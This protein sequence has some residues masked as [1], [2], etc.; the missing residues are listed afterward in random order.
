LG[1][2]KETIV[3]KI[4]ETDQFAELMSAVAR[5]LPRDMYPTT[6]QGWIRN[7]G[8]LEKV[9]RAALMSTDPT[10]QFLSEVIASGLVQGHADS[11]GTK[12]WEV[13]QN[14]YPSKF[15][16]SDLELVSFLEEDEEVID[17]KE[18]CQ[19]A[20]QFDANLGLLDLKKVFE[21][22]GEIPVSFQ[23]HI[24]MFTGTVLLGEYHIQ[25][26]MSLRWKN[27]QWCLSFEG[28]DCRY[29]GRVRLLRCKRN[30]G[31]SVI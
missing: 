1:Y 19:R 28:F 15:E 23:D 30:H 9:L 10:W 4:M 6:A 24:L 13:V 11:E 17:A 18:L 26:V 31:R 25:Y 16:V 14:V 5:S 21:R 20:V 12:R 3:K 29:G 22:R 8:A 2:A 7:Q 27:D